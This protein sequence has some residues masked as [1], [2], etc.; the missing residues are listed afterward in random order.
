MPGLDDLD[1]QL[2]ARLRRDGRESTSSLAKALHVARGTVQNRIARLV[3]DGTITRFTIEVTPAVDGQVVRAVTLIHVTAATARAV[4]RAV[5]VI[6]EVVAVHSTNGKWDL[7][8]NLNCGSLTELDA[9][10]AS[11]R[12]IAGV[13]TTETSILLAQL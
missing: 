4:A 8:V 13:S 3:R 7:V 1:R 10:L 9:A 2:I 5:R 12:A 6:P 11:L